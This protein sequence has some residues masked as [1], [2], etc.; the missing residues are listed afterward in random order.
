MSTEGSPKRDSKPDMSDRSRRT[1]VG[2]FTARNAALQQH[3]AAVAEAMKARL[4]KGATD[5]G[6]APPPIGESPQDALS[7]ERPQARLDPALLDLR[8]LASTVPQ[9]PRFVI[10]GYLPE[11][12][13][14]LFAGHGG[15]GKS[16]LSLA[17]AICIAAGSTF[18]G[19]KC[20]RRRVIFVSY[21]DSTVTLHWRLTKICDSVG[22]DLTSLSDWLYVFDAS[23]RGDPLWIEGHDGHSPTAAFGWLREQVNATGAQVLVLDGTADAFAGN[24]NARAQVRA[25]V[26][27][28]RRLMPADGA[29]LLLHHVDAASAHG[30]SRKGYSG[31]TA[32]HN[33]CRARWLLRPASEDDESDSARVVI[34]LC[35]SNHGKSG[36][37]LPIRFSESAGCFVSDGMQ[38]CSP[39]DRSLQDAEEREAVLELIRAADAAGNPLPAATAGT[40]TVYTTA[41]ARVDCPEWIKGR[42]GRMRLLRHVETLRQSGTIWVDQSRKHNGHS[43]EVLRATP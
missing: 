21:E 14:T 1:G 42:S 6:N 11:G 36:S 28:L 19:L 33:S 27:A 9:S 34:E 38:A 20:S 29:A 26:Q 23:D 16:L 32:W 37:V 41:T 12:Q 13:A 17:A 25:F 15:S 4:R 18:F 2:R 31:S 8:S 35:K 3:N 7:G 22:I 40:R 39:R 5:E 24:E 30:I 10:D 43:R